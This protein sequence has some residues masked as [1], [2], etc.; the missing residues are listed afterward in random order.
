VIEVPVKD[1]KDDSPALVV[2]SSSSSSV[3]VAPAP[4]R[5][6]GTP[7]KMTRVLLRKLPPL[8]HDG[9]D[10]SYDDN[11]KDRE[12]VRNAD[13][14]SL[15]DDDEEDDEE[16]DELRMGSDVRLRNLLVRFLGS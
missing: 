2:P 6:K 10:A 15:K 13:L 7:V 3:S 16:D 12:P 9:W 5:R 14:L 8:T 1:E 11:G 4:P